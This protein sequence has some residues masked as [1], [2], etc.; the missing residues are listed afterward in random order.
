M[1]VAFTAQP[2]VL[3]GEKV[4]FIIAG[5]STRYDPFVV[6]AAAGTAFTGWT[7]LEL[8]FGEALQGM[9]APVVLD[10]ITAALFLFF[11]LDALVAILTGFSAWD[12]AVEQVA[13][14][15]LALVALA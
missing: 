14:L 13:G 10:A 4:R 8:L 3:P 6:V 1:V 12:W 2:A 5:L 9:F 15:V 7:A 11:G